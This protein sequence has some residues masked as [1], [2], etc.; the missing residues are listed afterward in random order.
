MASTRALAAA[1]AVV[2]LGVAVEV[3]ALWPRWRAAYEAV[4][5]EPLPLVS[6]FA[7]LGDGIAI[8][9]GLACALVPGVASA[10]RLAADPAAL[11]RWLTYGALLGVAAALVVWASLEAPFVVSQ[12]CLCQ[13]PP[14]ALLPSGAAAGRP[15][16]WLAW[17]LLPLLATPVLAGVLATTTAWWLL[18]RRALA[19]PR[20]TVLREAA[21]VGGVAWWPAL[22]LGGLLGRA[23]T[24][25]ASSGWPLLVSPEVAVA[26]AVAGATCAAAAG[27][28]YR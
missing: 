7:G 28:R 18:A 26:G 2:W 20:G 4:G 21:C 22:V 13:Q 14:T 12:R 3:A 10:R 5:L 15:G 6:S 25:V 17:F 23:A 9:I 1:C 16:A 8:P 24:A 11:R 19:R 27:L